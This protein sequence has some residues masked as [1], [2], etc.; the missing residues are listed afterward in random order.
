MRSGSQTA[1][2]RIAAV[3]ISVI[4]LLSLT[5][6]GKSTGTQRSWR[7]KGRLSSETVA[8]NDRYSLFWDDA[9]GC[10]LLRDV[11]GE[12]CLSDILYGEY[13]NGT[14]SVN[15]GSSIN[16]GII[17]T[18]TLTIDT[19]RGYS[20]MQENGRIYSERI[21]GGIRVTYSF[22]AYSIAV[23]VDYVLREDGLTVS[24]DGGAVIEGGEKYKL[25]SVSLAPYL[26]H[27]R[28]T[29]DDSAYLFV[30]SGAGAL[31]YTYEDAD[32]TRKYTGEVYGEDASRRVAT[33][34]SDKEAVRLPV[35]GVK[36]GENAVLGIIEQGAGA[37][38]I[39]AQ[40]GYARAGYSN[41]YPTFYLRGY[42]VF[43]F[44]SYATGNN[45][46][47]RVSDEIAAHTF[48]ITYYPLSGDE[49]DYTGMAKRY[50]R[51]LTEKGLLEQQESA[52]A[53]YGIT[54]L[55]GTQVY[56]SLLGFPMEKLAALT[57]FRQ[58]E[59]IL[60]QLQTDTGIA[61]AVRL[62]AFSDKG[63]SLGQIAG[64]KSFPAV[65]GSETD[66]AALIA[67]SDSLYTDFELMRYTESGN[68]FSYGNDAAKTAIHYFA[69]QYAHT[70]LRLFDETKEYRI[71]S[72]DLLTKA[73]E[74]AIAK[75]DAYGT[76]GMAFSSLGSYAY[77][78][79][80][81]P[82]YAVKYGMETQTA[83]LLQ[84]AGKN[85]RIAVAGGNAYAACAANAVFDVPT[86]NGDNTVF[87]AEIPFY[88]MVFHSY[89]AMYSP[90]INCAD[91]PE[92]AVMLAASGGTALGFTL[93]QEYISDSTALANEKL[94]AT[95]Y[96]DNRTF[97]TQ[98]LTDGGYAA[99]YESVRDVG[100]QRH[101]WVGRYVSKT[102]FDNGITVYANHSADEQSCTAGVLQG[103]AYMVKKGG[104]Q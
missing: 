74:K 15:T 11:H 8:Q 7:P 79:Y 43:R 47:T 5:A 33:D 44:G 2:Y 71:L 103:Y 99:F 50:R 56:S 9:A 63:L 102:V 51:Y 73:M 23:P 22:N 31:M 14:L 66:Y 91:N 68:G 54:L 70:P 100:I 25:L 69:T 80:S 3:M 36:D 49:A 57:T 61:P 6:C 38:V 42:D 37:A 72:R 58:A 35:F 97:I 77:S 85:R 76:S 95:K 55:G 94:Y 46:T 16:I 45:I 29:D 96:E 27:A 53:P 21:D 26:C 75:A 59:A 92:R 83:S 24:V 62:S 52:A 88:Q 104:D 93:T 64:G 34:Y 13:Q 28:N 48:S 86:G 90:A 78:D 17:D 87:D 65:Y 98:L 67:A 10:V 1:F 39:E 82:E 40:A 101:E 81:A 89:R 20:E 32:G 60:T 41:I 84:A 30:P 19:L 18:T 4:M 12:V